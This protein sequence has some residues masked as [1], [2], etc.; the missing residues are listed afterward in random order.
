MERPS[1]KYASLCKNE[2]AFAWEKSKNILPLVTF[3]P[4]LQN[5]C[6]CPIVLRHYCGGEKM[7]GI[8]MH[9]FGMKTLYQSLITLY[10]KH[11]SIVS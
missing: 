9:V 4:L 11:F 8:L 5:I 10:A 6:N 2:Q 3:L 1:E 7:E